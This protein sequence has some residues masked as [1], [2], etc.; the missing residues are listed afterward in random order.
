[1]R[2]DLTEFPLL[3]V[4]YEMPSSFLY[5]MCMSDGAA[6]WSGIHACCSVMTLFLRFVVEHWALEVV[7]VARVIQLLSDQ[8][9]TG[10]PFTHFSFGRV[11]S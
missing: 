10:C 9:A 1:V 4:V 11:A 2:R 7:L 8:L 6:V 5:K 3:Q